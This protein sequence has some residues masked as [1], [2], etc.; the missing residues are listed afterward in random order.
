MIISTVPAVMPINQCSW[1]QTCFQLGQLRRVALRWRAPA[2][3][4]GVDGVGVLARGAGVAAMVGVL[5]SRLSGEGR[6]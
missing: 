2:F 5:M 6:R 3:G 1:N 4:R